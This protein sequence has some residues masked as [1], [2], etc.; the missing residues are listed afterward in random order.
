[1]CD[2]VELRRWR[3]TDLD[4][5]DRAINESLEHLAPWMPWA[6]GHGRPQTAGFLARNREEWE[7]G[8]AY[9][10]A[11]TSGG[12]VIGSC[13]LHR[14]IGEGGLEIGYWIHPRRTGQGLATMA[15]GALVRQGFRLPGT[16]RI[17]IHHD[18]AN[19]ASGAVPRRLGFTEI[20]RVAVPGGP[21]TSGATGIDVIWRLTAADWRA[22]LPEPAQ[23]AD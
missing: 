1:M 14:R 10:Y 3:T 22:R 23:P 19:T 5:L 15:A 16:D 4:V 2:R 13:G 17:E 8:E 6:A 20:T 21:A 12:A 9:G 7:T 11:I 18:A